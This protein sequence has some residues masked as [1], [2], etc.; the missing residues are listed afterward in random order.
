MFIAGLIANVENDLK[1][2]IALSTLR[3]L[4]LIIIILRIGLNF[5]A[6]YHLLTHAIFKSILFICAGIII[7]LIMNNQDIRLYGNLNRI[8]PFTIISFYVAN[9][10]LCGM[11]FISGFYSKDLIIEIVYSLKFNLVILRLIII[12]LVFTVS[13]SFRLYYY[14]FFNNLKFF[15]FNSFEENKFINFSIV[16]LIFIRIFLGAI[17]N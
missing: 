1:K 13:Y 14:L 16:L 8:L 5:I 11:P 3:Q 6:F 12:S 4:G 15:R 7:H 10:A 2:I 9:I 17:L